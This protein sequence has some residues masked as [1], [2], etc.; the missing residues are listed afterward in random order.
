MFSFALADQTGAL[1][2][3]YSE[4]VVDDKR[5]AADAF[6]DYILSR[7]KDWVQLAKRNVVYVRTPEEIRAFKN[8][9]HCHHCEKHF[10]DIF[11]QPGTPEKTFDHD[12]YT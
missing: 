10:A 7:E 5:T 2:E 12:H 8:A 6:I 9:T 3:E 4:V 1:I 11:R